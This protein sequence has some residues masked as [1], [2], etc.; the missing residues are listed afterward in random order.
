MT[1]LL[2]L[3][4]YPKKD[5]PD[6]KEKR[7]DYYR[8]YRAKNKERIKKRMRA[9]RARPENKERVKEMSRVDKLKRNFGLTLQEVDTMITAQNGLCFIC[10]KVP[11][12]KMAHTHLQVDHCH[13]TGKLRAMLCINC[14][15]GLGHSYEDP[16]LLRKMADYIE[17]YQ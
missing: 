10:G 9:Y 6:F 7:C 11:K 14:N 12:G 8:A 5:D 4:P 15:I 13:K 16:V 2:E 1:D 3:P 17:S